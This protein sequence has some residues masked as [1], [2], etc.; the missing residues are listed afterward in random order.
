MKFPA[1]QVIHSFFF[2]RS[3]VS[4][5]KIQLYIGVCFLKFFLCENCNFVFGLAL[6]FHFFSD[7]SVFHVRNLICHLF[8]VTLQS[9]LIKFFCEKIF[10]VVFCQFF[11]GDSHDLFQCAVVFLEIRVNDVVI[12]V[13]NDADQFHSVCSCP[14]FV[15]Q[16]AD[17][18]QAFFYVMISVLQTI[19]QDSNLQAAQDISVGWHLLKFLIQDILER[20]SLHFPDSRAFLTD[21]IPDC[22]F[23]TKLCYCSQLAFACLAKYFLYQ[24]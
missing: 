17:F 2:C 1:H 14:G 23:Y 18:A 9:F 19:T 5:S 8:D 24:I 7:S 21:F 16:I 20:F 11:H 10:P 4:F 22:F 12:K 13:I 15:D 3:E 6:F